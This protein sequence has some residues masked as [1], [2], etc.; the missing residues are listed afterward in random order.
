MPFVKNLRPKDLQEHC[1]GAFNYHP[2]SLE[3]Y[4]FQYNCVLIN[5]MTFLVMVKAPPLTLIFRIKSIF[6]RDVRA[7]RGQ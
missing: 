1:T 3:E 6:N 2:F 7:S 4:L 5:F